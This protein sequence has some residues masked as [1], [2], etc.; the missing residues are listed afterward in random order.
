MINPH[1]FP[2]S[3]DGMDGIEEVEV[4]ANITNFE[5]MYEMLKKS[6]KED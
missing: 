3:G 4:V 5:L 1:G 2:L 6:V